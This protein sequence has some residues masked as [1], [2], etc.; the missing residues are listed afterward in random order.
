MEGDVSKPHNGAISRL[1]IWQKWWPWCL[2]FLAC[3]KVTCGSFWST[4][5]QHGK[6][7]MMPPE[8]AGQWWAT[9]LQKVLIDMEPRKLS[10]SWAVS[11]R[12]C[13]NGCWEAQDEEMPPAMFTDGVLKYIPSTKF[14]IPDGLFTSSAPLVRM[15]E[16]LQIWGLIRLWNIFKDFTSWTTLI[17]KSKNVKYFKIWKSKMFQS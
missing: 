12:D 16:V 13:S 1:H 11:S 4:K 14:S 17:R 10:H 15:W 7:L 3:D 8:S 9:V 2:D 6:I 5:R